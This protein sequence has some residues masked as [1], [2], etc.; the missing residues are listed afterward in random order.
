MDSKSKQR[1]ELEE[2]ILEALVRT[3]SPLERVDAIHPIPWA[4]RHPQLFQHYK[5]YAPDWSGV[6]LYAPQNQYPDDY[7]AQVIS[8]GAT[9]TLAILLAESARPERRVAPKDLLE[10]KGFG[11]KMLRDMLANDEMYQTVDLCTALCILIAFELIYEGND[12]VA[13]THLAGMA[14]VLT[15]RGGIN[16][17]LA[18]PVIRNLVFAVDGLHQWIS[19]QPRLFP[20][21]DELALAI[22]LQNPFRLAIQPTASGLSQQRLQCHMLISIGAPVQFLL[23]LIHE[24]AEGSRKSLTDPLGTAPGHAMRQAEVL[25]QKINELGPYHAKFGLTSDIF[26]DIDKERTFSVV[27]ALRLYGLL[28]VTKWLVILQPSSTNVA[29]LDHCSQSLLAFITNRRG[30]LGEDIQFWAF[31]SASLAV[32]SSFQRDL[33]AEKFS[34]MDDSK[35]RVFTSFNPVQAFLKKLYFIPHLQDA[36]LESFC[37]RA[38]K[39]ER[40][41]RG[42]RVAGTAS[43]K[44]PA[45]PS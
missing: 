28:M 23:L 41:I 15:A 3:P 43:G 11:L 20:R 5:M 27:E 26:S 25:R 44:E 16:T 34:T 39:S 37:R 19:G 30:P 17:L 18:I 40:R 14:R 12:E 1:Q 13:R 33:F 35:K 36:D 6:Q 9:F 21:N 32:Q 29:S 42:G 24:V 10:I 8:H 38:F 45:E 22:G 31:I 2:E 4:K 7:S